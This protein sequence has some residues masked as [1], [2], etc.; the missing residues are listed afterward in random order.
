MLCDA[1]IAGA[2]L[3]SVVVAAPGK[4]FLDAQNLLEKRGFR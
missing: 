4:P 3:A 2:L 1:V